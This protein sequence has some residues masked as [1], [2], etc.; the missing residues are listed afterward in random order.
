MPVMS[1]HSSEQA[2]V[3]Q[4]AAPVKEGLSAG[5][6]SQGPSV[7]KPYS[8]FTK[9]ERWVIVAIVAFAALFRY[10]DHRLIENLI[11]VFQP[12]YCKHIFSR[13]SSHICGLPQINGTYQSHGN[14]VSSVSRCLYV[15]NPSL[16]VTVLR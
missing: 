4:V 12:P 11:D 6:A 14:S 3:V 9:R 8:I 1:S 10:V 16:T 15:N 7:E 13:Y 5:E 2:D